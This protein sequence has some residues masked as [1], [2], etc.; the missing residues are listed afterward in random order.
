MIAEWKPLEFIIYAFQVQ[1]KL[2]SSVIACGNRYNP[3]YVVTN[4]LVVI[5]TCY[6]CNLQVMTSHCF[7]YTYTDIYLL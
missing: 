6:N 3:F 7:I 5:P 4:F 2:A 1:Y